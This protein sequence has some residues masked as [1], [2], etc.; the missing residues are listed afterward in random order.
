MDSHDTDS[1]KTIYSNNPSILL[2][3]SLVDTESDGQLLVLGPF[4]DTISCCL[5][6]PSGHILLLGCL[7]GKVY[8]HNAA[9]FN[10]EQLNV[11]ESM[12]KSVEWLNW[13]PDSS[14]FLFGGEGQ[15]A[16][17]CHYR[18]GSLPLLHS[19]VT[20][21][22]T[23]CGKILVYDVTV[24]VV[25]S[26]DGAVYMT[27]FGSPEHLAQNMANINTGN[28]HTTGQAL[29]SEVH[30]HTESLKISDAE[31]ICLDCHEKVQ[32]A[33]VGTASGDIHFV[34]L[35]KLKLVHSA[36]G[37]H[38]ESVESVRFHPNPNV[39]LVASCGMDGNVIFWDPCKFSQISTV[40][41]DMG[42]T[43]LLWHPKKST[44]AIGDCSGGISIVRSG[45]ILK[46][47]QAHQNAVLDMAALNCGQDDVA[48]ISVS[49]DFTAV[50]VGEIFN[51][52]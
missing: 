47:V 16:Y 37:A 34:S 30:L 7:D 45:G 48:I 38:S 44:V 35:S 3:Y 13:H 10:Y 52:D 1:K 32:L 49:Q 51:T 5:Y 43:R 11:V 21:N 9:S 2:D 31:L 18:P 17:L 22:S 40:N 14:C 8:I 15:C 33:I 39:Q 42:L 46:E 36:M 50:I 29:H 28:V 27:K 4:G 24:S 25:G 26:D 6:S 12:L 19:I 23:Q 41:L 20:S